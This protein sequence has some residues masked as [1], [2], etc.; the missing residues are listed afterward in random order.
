MRAIVISNPNPVSRAVKRI[1]I[2]DYNF[3]ETRDFNGKKV[4]SN[5]KNIMIE[6]DEEIINIS[7][8]NFK[9][10]LL[11]FPSTHRSLTAGNKSLTVHC[12]G[13]FNEDES[14][15]GRANTLSYAN[16]C[17][18]SFAL[19]KLKE[20][21]PIEEFDVTLEATHHGP[22]TE[23]PAIFVEVGPSEEE[24]RMKDMLRVVAETCFELLRA[25]LNC[26]NSAIGF[27]GSHYASKHTNAV[28]NGK[29]AVGHIC[30]KYRIP[31]LTANLISQ[32]VEKTVPH[33]TVALF[34]KKSTKRKEWLRTELE[35]Y[36]VKIIQI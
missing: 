9:C 19:R 23:N 33:P 12:T 4:Y 16:S 22:L 29:Y 3:V 36:G 14:H 21:N 7:G 26:K 28:L 18:V 20:L 10:E 27:G 32:M 25:D 5:G 8:L 1:L 15:G 34:D 31:D 6:S 24:F 30:P 13:V 35:N 2:K 17:A 11:I